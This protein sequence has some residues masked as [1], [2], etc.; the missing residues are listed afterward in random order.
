MTQ[1]NA[2]AFLVE[3][4]DLYEVRHRAGACMF[5]YAPRSDMQDSPP[6][7]IIHACPCGCEGLSALYFQGL[8]N[9]KPEWSVEGSWIGYNGPTITCRPSIGIKLGC[10]ELDNRPDGYHWHGYLTNG[11]FEELP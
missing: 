2:K 10:G 4:G 6:V 8:G 5:L 9:G 3:P 7:G 1:R 11:V